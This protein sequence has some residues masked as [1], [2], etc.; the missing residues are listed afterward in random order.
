MNN[1]PKEL[2]ILYATAFLLCV[3]VHPLHADEAGESRPVDDAARDNESDEVESDGELPLGE[4]IVVRAKGDGDEGLNVRRIGRKEIERTGAASAVQVLEREPAF[5]ATTGSRGERMFSLRGFSQRQTAVLIDGIPA[6]APYEGQMDLGMVPADMIERITVIKGPG[7]VLYG[8]NGMGGA[9]NIIT[10]KPG[11]GPLFSLKEE[12]GV[13]N[14]TDTRMLHS[15]LLGPLA[16]T[17]SA[18][19][20][21]T[22]GYSLPRNFKRT[23]NEDG[24]VRENSDRHIYHALGNFRLR[25]GAS[26]RF[27]LG[28]SFIGGEKGIPPS[29]YEITPEYRRFTN[30]RSAN[31]YLV[32]SWKASRNMEIDEAVY[33]HYYEDLLDAYDDDGYSSQ[34]TKRAFHSL[35]QDL[36][37]GGRLRLNKRFPDTAIGEVALRAWSSVQHDRHKKKADRDAGEREYERTLFTVAPEA[38]LLPVK[39]WSFLTA[40][41]FDLEVPKD[42]PG[43]RADNQYGWGPLAKVA[44]SPDENFSVSAAVARR[45]RFPT[46][47]ERFSGTLKGN[48]PNPGLKPESAWHASL[49]FTYRPFREFRLAAAGF[50]AEVDDIISPVDI[51]GGKEQIRNIGRARLAGAEAELSLEPYHWLFFSAGYAFLHAR[52]KDKKPPFDRFEYSPAHKA[53]ANLAV[54]PLEWFEITNSVRMVGPQD[55]IRPETMRMGRLG[56]YAVWDGRI[57]VRQGREFSAWMRITNILDSLHQTEYG[58]PDPGREIWVGIDVR[59][60]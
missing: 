41:Q 38:E 15:M 50:D 54:K 46:L 37:I 12:I 8:P 7:S 56:A 47:K 33:L 34:E 43:G 42:P 35:M 57:D 32:H 22:D 58:F 40:F 29:I 24:G 5:Y 53:R 4:E 9:I 36:T 2:V 17:V 19:I 39:E 31:S 25:T 49:E 14:S 10:R 59:A 60:E 20:F 23:R 44:F 21:K 6:C 45:T 16:Y 48:V 13:L 27:V 28:G 30:W 26:H 52:L 11:K 55:F 1:I 3:F 18:G 51:G